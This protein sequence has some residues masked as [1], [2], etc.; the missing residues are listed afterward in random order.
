MTLYVHICQRCHRTYTARTKISYICPHCAKER[1]Q[2]WERMWDRLRNPDEYC[3]FCD[4]K[5]TTYCRICGVQICREHMVIVDE[6]EICKECYENWKT[7]FELNKMR[8]VS[9]APLIDK[10]T[11]RLRERGG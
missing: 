2:E 4:N 9:N 11:E 3:F 8:G 1:E 5:Q 6:R 7:K 10:M